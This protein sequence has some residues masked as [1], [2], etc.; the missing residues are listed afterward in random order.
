MILLDSLRPPTLL[1]PSADAYKDWLHL[2]IFDH[3]A[4]RVG[5][6]NVSLHGSPNDLRS[7]AAGAA[8]VYVPEVGWFGNIEIR[9]MREVV[10]NRSSIALERVALAVRA[11]SAA[12]MASVRDADSGLAVRVTATAV[13]P[14]VSGEEKLSLGGGWISWCAIPRL[15]LA[16]D[17]TIA[18]EQVDLQSASAYHDHNWGRWHWG[19]DLG[20]EWGC[21][22]APGPNGAAFVLSRTSDR[23]HRV[24]GNTSLV[25][26]AE[27][28]RRTFAGTA[29]SLTYSGTLPIARRIPGALAALHQDHAQLKL[30]GS[31]QISADD[32]IDHAHL[33]FSGQSAVQLIV[34]DPVIRGYSFIH[35]IAG[36]FSCSGRIG[37]T[38]IKS[39]GLGILE[40]VY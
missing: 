14:I 7:R 24:F 21:F 29:V 40:L 8:L 39:S 16:G 30:P 6:I 15:T 2:N 26:Q 4:G 13:A 35:E 20:W 3:A 9:G 19:D 11:N 28:K 1:D 17:W 12:V 22:L 23:A 36:A 38:E 18:G 33:E 37:G 34:A 10:I 32:G 27:G 5:L 31:L 25:V